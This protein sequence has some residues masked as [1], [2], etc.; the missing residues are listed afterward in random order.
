MRKLLTSLIVWLAASLA[1][2]AYAV[3]IQ[4]GLAPIII[5]PGPAP[6]FDFAAQ[7]N[8]AGAWWDTSPGRLISNVVPGVSATL[9]LTGQPNGP[10][11]IAGNADDGQFIITYD[12]LAA[13]A[14][15]PGLNNVRI[16]FSSGLFA[17]IP[18]RVFDSASLAGSSVTAAGAARALAAPGIQLD[19]FTNN[20]QFGTVGPFVGPGAFGGAIG[21]LPDPGLFAAVESLRGVLT[22]SFAGAAAGDRVIL[23]ASAVIHADRI[24]EPGTLALLGMGLAGLA[25]RRRRTW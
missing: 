14:V 9:T 12:P 23:P 4:I 19:G 2:S 21:P 3:T 25:A 20:G 5:L 1:T 11:G 17:P 6:N 15:P 7:N 18:Q 22:F 16:E 8:P 10:D 13:G 24:P